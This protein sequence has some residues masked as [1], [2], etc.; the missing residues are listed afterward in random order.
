[1]DPRAPNLVNTVVDED[2]RWKVLVEVSPRRRRLFV[3]LIPKDA[4]A[5]DL[6]IFLA[7]VRAT[8]RR[9]LGVEP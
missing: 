4:T 3:A 6:D 2:D 1:M 7:Q 5:A 9:K 8:V